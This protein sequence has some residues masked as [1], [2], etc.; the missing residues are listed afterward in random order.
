MGEILYYYLRYW[1]FVVICI[2]LKKNIYV[3]NDF[4]ISI[5]M[6]INVFNLYVRIELEN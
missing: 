1:N 5:K 6:Y 4:I 2:K 3:Y